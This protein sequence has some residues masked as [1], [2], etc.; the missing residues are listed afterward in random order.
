[1]GLNFKNISS[2]MD[3]EKHILILIDL[4]EKKELIINYKLKSN[5]TTYDRKGT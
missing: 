2:L 1:M 3:R 5:L 4:K